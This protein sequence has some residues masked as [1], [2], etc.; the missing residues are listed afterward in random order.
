[1]KSKVSLKIILLI[2]FI[3]MLESV[4]EFFFKK[5]MNVIGEF[6]YRGF[7]PALHYVGDVVS[8]PWIMIGLVIIIIET[9]LWIAVLSKIDLSLAFPLAS[10]SYVFILLVSA[11]ILHEQVSVNRVIG[12]VL[13]M[14]GIVIVTKS[15]ENVSHNG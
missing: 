11:F 14:I 12:T 15:S 8:N 4:Y 2:V 1:M 5:G 7:N 9:V 13:I 6:T 3:D 10:S